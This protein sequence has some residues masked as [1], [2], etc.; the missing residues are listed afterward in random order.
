MDAV[1][2]FGVPALRAEPSTFDI[3]FSN[4]AALPAS[5]LDTQAP[6]QTI[7]ATN[8]NIINDPFCEWMDGG[9]FPSK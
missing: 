7:V 1:A 5:K 8:D 2:L 4:G 3:P 9:E 6:I